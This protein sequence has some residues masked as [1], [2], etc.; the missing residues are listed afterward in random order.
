MRH[1]V[2]HLQPDEFVGQ[3]PQR[4]PLPPGRWVATGQG[5]QVGF[6]GSVE[7]AGIQAGRRLAFQC[8]VQAVLDIGAANAADRGGMDLDRPGDR[9]VGPPRSPFALIGL[10][11]DAGMGQ[12]PGRRGALPDQGPQ[13]RAF[14]FGEDDG[15]FG[16]A[17]TGL[18]SRNPFDAP[19][20]TGSAALSQ[21]ICD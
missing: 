16:L 8:G 11:Q 1:R 15:L 9:G 18:P 4:P 20:P 21:I 7:A 2:H 3:Q 14:G 5:D 19:Q 10:E 17:H 13:V 12:P 6:G